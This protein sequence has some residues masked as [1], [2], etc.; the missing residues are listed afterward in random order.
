LERG[1]LKTRTRLS[2][3]KRKES[4]LAQTGGE[5]EEKAALVT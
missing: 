4:F 3:L 2:I 5:V 1:E